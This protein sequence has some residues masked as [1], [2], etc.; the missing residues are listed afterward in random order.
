MDWIG[1]DHLWQVK[2]TK[3]AANRLRLRRDAVPTQL[4]K[5]GVYQVD[6]NNICNEINVL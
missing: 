5:N 1:D 6:T 2:V 4:M 3:A